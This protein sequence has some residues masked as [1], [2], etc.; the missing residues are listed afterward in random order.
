LTLIT[1]GEDGGDDAGRGDD[2]EGGDDVDGGDNVGDWDTVDGD[3]NGVELGAGESGATAGARE[4]ATKAVPARAMI[5]SAAAARPGQ[6]ARA[7]R[8]LIAAT[9][10][11]RVAAGT[12]TSADA[13]TS[14]P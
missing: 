10:A 12:G 4:P 13:V 11:A 9:T 8:R 2:V 6:M 5:S 3:W 7:G 1:G 14:A